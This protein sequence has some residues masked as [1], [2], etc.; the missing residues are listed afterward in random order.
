MRLQLFTDDDVLGA[1]REGR[2]E[3]CCCCGRKLPAGKPRP[4]RFERTLEKD[5]S[6]FPGRGCLSDLSLSGMRLARHRIA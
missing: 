6:D 3:G 5:E 4:S 1:L 2:V